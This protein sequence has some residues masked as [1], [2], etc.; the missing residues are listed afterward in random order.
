MVD[1]D[2]FPVLRPTS[3]QS[4]LSHEQ[5]NMNS[6]RS[7]DVLRHLTEQSTERDH[8][9]SRYS[10]QKQA[11]SDAEADAEC[12]TFDFSTNLGEIKIPRK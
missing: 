8:E 7:E 3:L 11:D 4:E 10:A 9:I 5:P 6:G 1:Q 12:S 2:M